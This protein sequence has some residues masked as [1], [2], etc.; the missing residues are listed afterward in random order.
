MILNK[1]IVC[2]AVFLCLFS[3][4]STLKAKEVETKISHRHQNEPDFNLEKL[5]GSINESN[6]EFRDLFYSRIEFELGKKQI[7]ERPHDEINNTIESCELSIDHS[8][9]IDFPKEKRNAI[10]EAQRKMLEEKTALDRTLLETDKNRYVN[11]LSFHF[12][13]FLGEV[14]FILT[15]EEFQALFKISKS[16]IGNAFEMLIQS[17]EE[18]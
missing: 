11:D 5:S 13:K 17:S 7:Q 15:E 8:L 10:I 9:G 12:E 6:K 3:T 4:T 2:F 14:T 18:H 16:E 1:I